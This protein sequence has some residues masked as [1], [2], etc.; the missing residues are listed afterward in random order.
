M[1]QY[2]CVCG[3]IFLS[4]EEL[5]DHYVMCETFRKHVMENLPPRRGKKQIRIGGKNGRGHQKESEKRQV[6]T[7]RG[8]GTSIRE[9]GGGKKEDGQSGKKKS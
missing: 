5:S 3:A 6:D 2:V 4:E 1:E 8:P 9:L 7:S